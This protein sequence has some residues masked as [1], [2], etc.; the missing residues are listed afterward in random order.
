MCD[1]CE[2]WDKLWGLLGLIGALAVSMPQARSLQFR[3]LE[4]SPE[5]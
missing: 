1:E 4:A 5:F 2:V 3:K